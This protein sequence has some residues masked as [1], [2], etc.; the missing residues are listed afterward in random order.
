MAALKADHDIGLLGQPID[1]LAFAFVT[2]LGADHD[3]I[4]HGNSPQQADENFNEPDT[5][6]S[7]LPRILD[8]A[9]RSKEKW[10]LKTVLC[11]AKLL[12]SQ[13]FWQGRLLN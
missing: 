1:D 6:G 10:A 8:D 2:P 4:R 9:A 3:N 5:G 13:P 12:V 7:R 11:L